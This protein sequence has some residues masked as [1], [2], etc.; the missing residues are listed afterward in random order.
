M[1]DRPP[2]VLVVYGSKR[3]G[4]AEIADALVETL[5]NEGI[6]ADLADA[7]TIEDIDDYD[8]VV[9]GGALYMHRWHRDA[10]RF[11]NHHEAA[12]RGKPVWLFSSGPFDDQAN[13]HDVPPPGSVAAI[14][15]RIH[16]RDH[17]TFVGSRAG[18]WRAWH[19]I[20]AWARSLVPEL[21]KRT[22]LVVPSEPVKVPHASHFPLLRAF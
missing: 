16:A 10:R 9:V 7:A 20:R 22:R 1:M 12:L 21:H 8:A 18:D 11:V 15:N 17:V 6:D 13:S 2:H 3:G 14:A 4:T 19:Q 5:L